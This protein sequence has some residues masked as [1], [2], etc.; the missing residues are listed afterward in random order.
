MTENLIHHYETPDAV[1][2]A[3]ASAVIEKL[4]QLTLNSD[5]VHI[6][7]TGGTVGILTLAKWSDHALRDS[8]EYSK[9]H[10]WWGDERFVDQD[11]ADRN[12]IQAWDA[13]LANIEVP[14]ENL[15]EFPSPSDGSTLEEARADFE[16]E[17]RSYN[18]V[19]EFALMGMGP[20]GHVASLFPG[21]EH[22]EG[23]CLILAEH[24]S[25]KP[26]SER[27]SLS[28]SVLNTAKEIWFLIAG[29]DKAAPL[30][31][32]FSDTP[33]SLPVGRISGTSA[34]RWFIDSA[35]GASLNQTS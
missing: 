25:P 7:I 22:L 1:A 32:A 15:H 12:F 8:I 35:A 26:P 11:S 30:A 17:F 14:F 31:T 34:N 28:Y 27:L 4:Q 2:T 19:F 18:P 29:A 21:H 10:F 24:D 9:V 3:A 6:A 23:Q 33:D 16:E 5:T 13:L 20:D